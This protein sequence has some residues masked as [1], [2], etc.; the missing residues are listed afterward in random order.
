MF[1]KQ[2]PEHLEKEINEAISLKE[3]LSKKFFNKKL[4]YE[5]ILF[6]EYKINKDSLE[7]NDLNQNEIVIHFDSNKSMNILKI[8]DHKLKEYYFSFSFKKTT[9]DHINFYGNTSQCIEELKNYNDIKNIKNG[10]YFNKSFYNCKFCSVASDSNE[11]TDYYFCSDDMICC[12]FGE[13]LNEPGFLIL[14]FDAQTF[15]LNQ[16]YFCSLCTYQYKLK[17]KLNIYQCNYYYSA[18][19]LNFFKYI[20]LQTF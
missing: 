20:G 3:K 11:I 10:F 2:I 13:N 19:N 18:D 9:K 16:I 6:I 5:K 8:K 12:D 15:N 4:S 17:Y 14:R 1:M 7:Q